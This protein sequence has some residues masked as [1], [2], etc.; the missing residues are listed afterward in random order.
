MNSRLLTADRVHFANGTPAPFR[1]KDLSRLLDQAEHEEFKQTLSH[2]DREHLTSECRT[3]ASGFLSAVPSKEEGGAMDPAAF[4]TEL[5]VRLLLD[6]NKAAEF[7]P[8]CDGVEDTKCHHARGL[9]AAG[10]DRVHKHNSVRNEVG[11]FAGRASLNPELEKA[12]LLPPSPEEPLSN[13]RRPADVYLPSWAGGTPAALDFACTSPQRQDALE[14]TAQGGASAA[15]AYTAFKKQFLDTA[16][17]CSRQGIQF[18]PM[19]FEPS[20][21]WAPESL[22]T[23]REIARISSLRS[24][25]EESLMLGALLQRLSVVIRTAGARAVL[26]RQALAAGGCRDDI[27]AAGDALMVPT[28]EPDC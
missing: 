12:G 9:C 17:Q 19:V 11:R 14:R 22:H 5:R 6:E 16:E 8:L 21:A 10:P 26:R 15:E 4:V 2:S 13:R 25:T 3:G 27:G 24:G 23:L 28:W 7:C 18:L 20:G 1:Q